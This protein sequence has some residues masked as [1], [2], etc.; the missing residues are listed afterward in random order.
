MTKFSLNMLSPDTGP[1]T[2][3]T[4]FDTEEEAE[5]AATAYRLSEPDAEFWT[6]AFTTCRCGSVPCV[7]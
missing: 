6:E 2:M 7:F 3:A 1:A 5:A 4:L